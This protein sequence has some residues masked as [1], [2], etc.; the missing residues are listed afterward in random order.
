MRKKRKVNGVCIKCGENK[1]EP[2]HVKCEN[3]LTKQSLAASEKAKLNSSQG[4][5]VKCGNEPLDNHRFCRDCYLKHIAS[6][7]T[8]N[9]K[10]WKLIGQKFNKQNGVCPY[11]GRS[12]MLGID[13]DLDHIVPSSC[14]GTNDLKNLHWVFR[15]ANEMKWNYSEEEFLGLVKE[16]YLH[17]FGTSI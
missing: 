8:N 17:R 16:I 11:T 2:P 7:R 4:L 10:N 5:C 3:C 9:V 1:V 12:L 15:K 13:A 6:K 14:G